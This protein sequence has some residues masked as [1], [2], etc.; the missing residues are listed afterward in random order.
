MLGSGVSD[1]KVDD[2]GVRKRTK[3]RDFT[4]HEKYINIYRH[5]FFEDMGKNENI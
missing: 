4:F 5:N 3:I 2:E 1:G